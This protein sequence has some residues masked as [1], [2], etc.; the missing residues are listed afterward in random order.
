MLTLL[1]VGLYILVRCLD[2]DLFVTTDEPFWLGRSA[3]FYRALSQ[4]D[5]S[6]T[7]QMA[8]PGVL[9]MW[10]GTA[11]Y[12]FAFPDYTQSVTV[13]LHHV[14]GIDAI[15]KQLGQDPMQLLVTARVFKILLQAI[16]F[17]LSLGFLNRLFGLWVMGLGGALIV[18]D[19]FVSGMDS[20]FH[21]DGLFA[22]TAFAAML[23]LANAAKAN[24][25]AMTPWLI[26]G[27]LAA[28][29]WMTRATGL[30]IVAVVIGIAVGQATARFRMKGQRSVRTILETPAFAVMLWASGAIA[31]SLALLPSLW[32]DPFGTMQ[33]VWDWSSNAATAG[34][35]RPTFL[36]GDVHVGDPGL[37]FYPVTLIWRL[38]PFALLGALI[39][40]SLMP[41]AYRR[42][43]ISWSQLQSLAIL[44][45]FAMIYGGAMSGGAKKFDRYILP[46]YPLVAVFAAMGV[47]LLGRWVASRLPAWRRLALP[48]MAVVLVVGQA[49]SLISV[50][51]YRLDYYNPVF[52][53]LARAQHNVQVGWGEG[54]GEAMAFIVDDAKGE[55][56]IVQKSSVTP[57]LSYFSTPN[58]HFGGF[59]FGTPAGWYETDYFVVGIQE[60]QRDLSRSYRVM[61]EYEPAHIVE[62][63]G[64]PFFKVYKPTELPLPES[65]RSATGCSAS[66]GDELQ[67]MQ[68]IGREDR[69]DLY[70]LSTGDMPENL[71]LSAALIAPEGSGLEDPEQSV[72]LV[73]AGSGKVFKTTI[74]DPRDGE[75]AP[76]DQYIMSIQVHDSTTGNVLPGVFNGASLEDDTFET[77]SECYSGE[78]ATP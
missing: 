55:E 64:V 46:V 48:A 56:V 36:L 75:A 62:I 69:I 78:T 1:L 33:Q 44:A 23:A 51:P 76:L 38:T 30:A 41:L 2:L 13:N 47:V 65:L 73:P 28:C 16:F 61:Q 67:L 66:F 39:S 3:N 58:I 57:V 32:V 18:F 24:P 34:H 21:V 10:A 43:W 54:G 72:P 20:L 59:G 19:P 50:L 22:I 71:E 26:A 35:E 53:G 9:T 15:L 42:G 7:Y 52:G 60:W 63:E 12:L 31:A 27:A 70:W 74:V 40:L 17:A 68:I 11:A 45:G 4:R 37:T 14:Y 29:A 77:N 5:F 6:H 49:G 8:H 25:D